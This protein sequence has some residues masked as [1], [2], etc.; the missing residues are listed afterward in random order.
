MAKT[1]VFVQGGRNNEAG[2]PWMFFHLAPFADPTPEPVDLVLFDYPNGTLKTWKN[3]VLKRGKPPTQP[4]DNEVDLVPKVKIRLA[5][6]E[7]DEAGPD[8]PSVLALYNWVKGQPGGS[9]RSL[10]VFSHGYKSGP[11][12]WNSSEF[13]PDGKRRLEPNDGRPRDINDT[14]FRV[15]D[16]VGTNPLAGQE[17]TQ[18]AKAFTSDALI[19]LWGCVAPATPR[20][21][22]QKYWSLPKGAKGDQLRLAVLSFYLLELDNSYP[23]RMALTLNLPVWAAPLGFGSNAF[24][25][26]PTNREELEVTYRGNFPPDLTKDQWWRVSWFFR[27]QDR[28]AE[29]YR[30]VLK[31]RIDPIDYVEHTKS[32]YDAVADQSAPQ[33]EAGPVDSPADLQQRLTDRVD[34]LR[35]G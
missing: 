32:W 5:K 23:M 11:I 18:F 7:I 2:F 3:H 15:R 20:R 21:A 24:N 17:G 8:R 1:V 9:I 26:I 25:K 34:A 13:D 19:K 14:D 30:D 28:G 27:N 33:K 10:Q 12:I 16:F 6:G 29:F 4:P 22:L 31:A 35:A